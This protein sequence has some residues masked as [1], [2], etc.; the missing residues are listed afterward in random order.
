MDTSF[1]T[2]MAG[3][4]QQ[5]A[6]TLKTLRA[7]AALRGYS[8]HQFPL[9]EGDG[10]MV[11]RWNLSRTLPDLASVEAFLDRAGVPHG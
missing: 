10:F 1:Q 2:A 4:A 9:A 6:K 11:S 8:L 5:C 3:A 7:R